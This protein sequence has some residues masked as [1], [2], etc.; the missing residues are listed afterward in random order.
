MEHDSSLPLSRS[1]L[2][3]LTE[4]WAN[5]YH[6]IQE[7]R[8]YTGTKWPYHLVIVP[9]EKA[10]KISAE[11]FAKASEKI[12]KKASIEDVHAQMDVKADSIALSRSGQSTFGLM[13]E[14]EQHYLTDSRDFDLDEWYC[15]L[16]DG[17][18][19]PFIAGDSYWLLYPDIKF[20][21]TGQEKDCNSLSVLNEA[22]PCYG[23]YKHLKKNE[24]LS[25]EN[26]AE[27]IE[28]LKLKIIKPE[29]IVGIPPYYSEKNQKRNITNAIAQ[30]A[31]KRIDPNNNYTA[32]DIQKLRKATPQKS[33]NVPNPVIAKNPTIFSTQHPPFPHK[34][35]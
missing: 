8:M 4:K 35:T 23:V 9:E 10:K 34:S 3:L 16:D 28:H 26:S 30:R 31:L 14:I 33:R 32:A 29:D 1:S 7:V 18:P 6:Y 13:S 11:M 27:A 5:R 25:C 19:N 21:Y 22:D 17:K 2:K 15:S 12:D 20:V 24:N